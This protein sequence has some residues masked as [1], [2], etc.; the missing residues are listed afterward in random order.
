VALDPGSF[1]DPDSRVLVAGDAVY[2]LLSERG[3]EDWLALRDAPVFAQATAAG[4]LVATEAVPR[5]AVPE[6]DGAP[7]AAVLRHERVPF[8]SYP[9]EWTFGMLRD[10]ALL[11]LDLLDR[12]LADGLIL[13]DSSPYNVQWRGAAPVFIDVGSFERL[14]AG[15]PWVGYRQFCMLFLYPLMLTAFRG[16]PFQ[17]WL[18]GS[19]EGIAPADAARL[20]AWRDRLRRGVMTNVVLHARLERR[21]AGVEG[22]AVRR[23]LRGAG[24][25]AELVKAN[26]RK[27]RRLV[28]RLRWEPGESAW[29]AY[30]TDDGYAD[31]D[32]AAKA[33]FVREAAGRRRRR[34]AWDLGANDG[35]YARIAADAGCDCVVAM[36][37]DHP[38]VELLHRALRD[39]GERRILPLV[40][41]VCDPSPALGWAGRERPALPDRGR[42]DLVLCLALVH[43]LAITRNV[44]L[45]EIVAWLAGLGGE[46]VVELPTREDPMVARLLAAKNEG[47]HADYELERFEHVLG[48]AFEVRRTQRL[49]SGTRVLFEAAPRGGA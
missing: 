25:G 5:E 18:R 2:R 49:P 45:E 28:E 11:Q 48:E 34:L 1:R 40:V 47:A 26:V 8:V 17:P 15:E 39:A 42:P 13:K 31:A 12:A 30:G 21:Y 41:D 10:A 6:L 27:M 38:T 9:Y 46:V 35:D 29:T 3:N 7:A 44:P 22:R 16:V 4:T 36:D 43:H 23:E 19:L 37:A 24:F 33:A 32:R 20:L 14:R